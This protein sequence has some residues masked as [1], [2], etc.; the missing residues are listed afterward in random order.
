ML[1]KSDFFWARGAESK[2]RE[3]WIAR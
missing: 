2:R 1:T 3:T